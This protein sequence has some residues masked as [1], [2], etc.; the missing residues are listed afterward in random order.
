MSQISELER[1]RRQKLALLQE[2]GMDPYP[3]RVERT[4]SVAEAMQAF[5]DAGE[6]E[7]SVQVAVVGR[8][9]SIRNMG[10]STFAHIEDGSGKIQL[11]LR[12]NLVGEDKKQL[13]DDAFDNLD[14]T[15]T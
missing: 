3:A 9:R 7:D 15:L 10:K 11:Y 8:L 13:F 2:K 6:E 4:H 5:Q 12:A 1:V 14:L